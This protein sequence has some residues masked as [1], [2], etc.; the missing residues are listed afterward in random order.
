MRVKSA[1]V[2]YDCMQIDNLK[3]MLE[4]ST[5]K[6]AKNVAFKYKSNNGMVEITYER[7]KKD[8]D[9]LGEELIN[10]GLKNKRIAVIGNNGYNWAITYLATVCGV[11][12]IVPID[13][14]L[15]INEIENLL[16]RS[17][18]EAIFFDGK[19]LEDILKIK[20]NNNLL[21]LYVCFDEVSNVA[22]NSI[23]ELLN[24]GSRLIDRGSKNY[25]NAKIDS[26]CM[27]ILLFTS[28]TTA[29]S[30]GVMLSHHNVC[31]N[32]MG[33]A[34][35][36]KFR[37]DDIML[38]FLPIHHTFEATIT[39]L[40]GIYSGACIAF[41]EG[42]KY[43]I[44]N[45]SD[46]NISIFTTVPLVL[47]NMYKKVNQQV[48]LSNGNLTGDEM[49]KKIAP[50]LRFVLVGAAP[51]NKDVIVGLEEWGVDVH[52]GYGLTETS[53]VLTLET[54]NMK[55][56]GSIGVAIPSV[57]IEI[58]NPNG[59]GLGEIKAKGP[60]VMLGY[61]ENE[62]ATNEVLKSGWF[63][64]GDLGYVDDEGYLFITGRKKNVIVLKNGKNIFPEEIEVLLNQSPY[65]AE[66]FVYAKEYEDDGE[67]T[68]CAKIVCNKEVIENEFP[69]I[70][71]DEL[72]E[73]MNDHRKE[74]NKL[75]PLYK[76][77]KEITVTDIPLV[78]TTTGKI[79]RYAQV[80]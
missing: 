46:F 13:K 10:R 80:V 25:I 34:Q 36:I 67:I 76:Y 72:I 32:I 19:Y 3:D 27:N 69:D 29:N 2:I 40:N 43:V 78:K 11:G 37:E 31:S 12:I 18:A 66:S 16:T 58:D 74:V 24:N 45:L 33:L 79:K 49:L 77:I 70:T 1:E 9:S 64:T 57:E 47:E 20:K 8:V 15:P 75:L 71:E 38:S 51:L 44:Q 39:L 4:K 48:E 14:A 21:K 17:R 50:N 22:V 56:A 68:L 6:H 41:S 73:M 52:Q 7:L 53:P 30:K 23:Y 65:V 55:K 54:D 63:Y 59:E 26:N 5:K 62:V 61:Y 60:N 35:V 28:G 42:L